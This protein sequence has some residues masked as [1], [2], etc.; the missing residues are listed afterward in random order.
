MGFPIHELMM[1]KWLDKFNAIRLSV[2]ANYDLS[3]KT[4]TYVV[5]TQWNGK[6]MKEM[7]QYLLGV[8]TQ[9]LQGRFPAQ[10]PIYTCVIDC[11]WA[12]LG[13]HIAARY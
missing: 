1:H 7:S 9:A 10:C 13:F 12:V 4:K 11:K 5:V 8:V 6:E 2:S 3:P